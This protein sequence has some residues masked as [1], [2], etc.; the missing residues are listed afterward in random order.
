[1][2]RSFL[3]IV[4]M[5]MIAGVIVMSCGGSKQVSNSQSSD[6]DREIEQKKKQM[7]LDDINAE[8]EIKKKRREMELK[9]IENEVAQREQNT[10]KMVKGEQRT[11]IFCLKEAIDKPGEYMGGL[12]V[13]DARP[14]RTRAIL[15]A[16]R[17]AVSDIATRYIGMIKNA[18]EDYNKDV[19]VPSGKKMYESSLEGGAAT[20]GTKVI[21]KYAN[22][23]CREVAQDAT[24]GWIGYVAVHVFLE[25]AKKGLAEE[26]EVRKVDYDKKK[27]FDKMDVEL[28]ADE[29]KHKT[30]LAKFD[31]Q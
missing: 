18:I 23:I 29:E 5:A 13:V 31:I 25:D 20:I 28:K 9:D 15:D 2:K 24:G 16:N 19:N 21:D 1:M 30:E 27:F 17:A 8:A 26:L 11:L 12:G 14:D 7:E 22:V 10:Q 4:M 3:K 6:L